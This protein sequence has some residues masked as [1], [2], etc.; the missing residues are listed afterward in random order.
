MNKRFTILMLIFLMTG[1][2]QLTGQEIEFAPLDVS[3]MDMAHYPRTSAYNN[4]MSEDQKKDPMIKVLYCR[5]S[6]KD[7]VIFGGL[8]PFGKLWRLGA[9]E[10]TEVSFMQPVEIGDKFVSAGTYTVNATIYPDH[11]MIHF[12]TELGVAGT[13]NLDP[14]KIVASGKAKVKNIDA[15]REAFTIGFQKVNES[16]VY[17]V[18]EWERT[19]A[20]LPINF[21][22]VY[23]NGN[24]VS[25]LDLAQFPPRSRFRNFMDSEEDLAANVPQM[26]VIYSRPQMRGRTIFGNLIKYGEPWRLGANE[27]TLITFH[28]DV[29]IGGIEVKEGTYGMM[30]VPGEK[31]WEFVLHENTDSW[32]I[33]NHDDTLNI[34]S[35]KGVVTTTPE[36]MEALSMTF[37]KQDEKTVHLIVAWEN[38]MVRLPI[39]MK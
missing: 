19:R 12:S 26:R 9:N 15:A 20:Y 16:K 29:M 10:A 25:P 23:L 17:M 21:N 18:F 13:A 14:E 24:D 11:W 37:D 38:T 1:G 8:V 2:F 28:N 4:Y 34:A 39:T 31:E 7:R 5:P 27:T 30:A 33:A 36:T 32:G 35:A 22:P 3:P 6:M